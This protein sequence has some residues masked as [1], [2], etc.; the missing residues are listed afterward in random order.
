MERFFR[1]EEEFGV[2][3]GIS[4]L[5]GGVG[6]HPFVIVGLHVNLL[7]FRGK[8]LWIHMIISPGRWKFILV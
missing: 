4:E 6:H 8:F 1:G 7:V 3:D 2:A 5:H